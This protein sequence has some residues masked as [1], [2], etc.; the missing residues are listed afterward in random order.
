MIVPV[1][2]LVLAVASPPPQAQRPASAPE[3]DASYYFLV[4]R[5]LES[6][7]KVPEAIEALKKAVALDP[8]DAEPLAELAGLYARQDNATGSVAAAEGALQIDP[9]N[10]EANRI[11]GS[12]LAAL[13]EQKQPLK[14]GD[15]QASY[16]PRAIAALE[17]AHKAD[18]DDLGLGFTLAGLYLDN[19]RPADAIPLL[20]RVADEQPQ[21]VQ[22][23]LLLAEAQEASGHADVAVGTLQTVLRGQPKLLRAQVQLAELYER[24]QN[25]STAADTWARAQALSPQ[26]AQIATR[27]ASALAKAG[28]ST[29]AIAL[30]QD[31]LKQQPGDV[32]LSFMLAQAQHDAGDLDSAE[33]TA[34]SLHAAHPDDTRATYLFAQMLDAR[35]RY[36]DEIDLV[37]PEI[38]TLRAAPATADQAAMLL[39]SEGLALQQLHKNDEAIAVFKDA[40]TLAPDD[41]LRYVLLIQGYTAAKREK[42][43]IDEGELAR[44]KFAG[45]T[46]VLYQLG[47][48]Y[49]RAGRKA[50]AEHVFRDLIAHDPLDAPALNYL[51]YMFAEQGTSLDEA[52]SFIERALKVE[53]E[54]PSYLDSLGW[55]YLQQGKLDLADRPLTTAADKLPTNSVIQEHLGDLR[56]KQNRRA[57]AIAA[58]QRALA[59]DGEEIDR[60][61]IEKK[62]A[63]ARKGR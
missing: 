61:K 39:G 25:W 48:A 27:R 35:G 6:Q 11:L 16:P 55:T 15:D 26:N 62:I 22:A 7:D 46:S 23:S 42:D 4:G 3:A 36:Q 52:V 40:L 34:R 58:W 57:D 54:N 33:A 1:L 41:P 13:I 20:Q 32:R 60:A 37:K 56:L 14:P 28:R 44:Q 24:Q 5:H 43:A 18:P 50:D 19:N 47:E 53:P 63:A 49:D 45:D 29:D 10:A 21:Y 30:L 31:A 51:G 59:G 2:W 17:I 38:A 8:S 12:V 9:Q